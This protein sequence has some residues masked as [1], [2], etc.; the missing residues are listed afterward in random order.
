MRCLLDT[1]VLIDAFAGQAD[2]A[3][4]LQSLRSQNAEWIG[5]SSITRLEI[6][7]FGGLEPADENGLKELLAEFEE[8]QVTS[9]VIE[10]AIALRKATRIK[11]P[12]ALIAATALVHRAQ[13][14]TRNVNDFANVSEITIINS[15]VS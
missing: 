6:L 13:L 8:A 2:A 11:V 5:Y 4:L 7:G 15:S 1:N 14:I 10:R 3:R 9:F 12:D